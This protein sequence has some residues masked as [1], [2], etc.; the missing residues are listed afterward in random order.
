[1]STRLIVHF[2]LV[3]FIRT[4]RSPWDHL[5]ALRRPTL[6]SSVQP[7]CSLSAQA[8]YYSRYVLLTNNLPPDMI[9]QVS[10]TGIDAAWKTP[11][12]EACRHFDHLLPCIPWQMCVSR[13]KKRYPRAVSL[14]R[15]RFCSNPESLSLSWPGLA[16]L[17]AHPLRLSS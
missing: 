15:H 12:V 11:F 4:T 16:L 8:V 17:H 6:D 14:T 13:K 7:S 3:I 1:M 10:E 9:E 2:V 5:H